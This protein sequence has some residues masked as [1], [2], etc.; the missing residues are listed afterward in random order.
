MPPTTSKPIH[1]APFSGFHPQPV[2]ISPLAIDYTRPQKASAP[3][4][5]DCRKIPA[6]KRVLDIV[7]VVLAAP[8]LIP[9][10]AVIALIIK[11]VSRGPVL[12]KQKRI[13]FQGHPFSCLKFRTMV[14]NADTQFHAGHL[15]R[16]MSANC[17]MTKLDARD[18]RLIPAGRL[19]RSLGLDEL[20][21]LINVLRGDMSLVGPRPCLPYEYEKY[22]PRHRRRCETLPGLTGLWQVNGKNETTFEEMISLDIE[23]AE[24]KSLWLDLKI[25][26]LT[27]PV[28]LGQ[29]CELRT[30]QKAGSSNGA[31]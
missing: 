15:N 13:G 31:V 29:A 4:C 1:S 8:V 23:Y 20:P 19:L 3:I 27:I 25:I 18:P 14:V 2:R 12:F 9:F 26:A 24:R 10:A 6:W 7:G 17:P 5:T 28:I 22:L 21:Q 16:L 30:N 11:A